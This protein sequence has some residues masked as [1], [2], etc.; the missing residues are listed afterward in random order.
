MTLVTSVAYKTLTF[1]EIVF[2]QKN[3]GN[4]SLSQQCITIG[5]PNTEMRLVKSEKSTLCFMIFETAKVSQTH[6]V[7]SSLESSVTDVR[8]GIVKCRMLTGT[9][10]LQTNKQKFSRSTVSATCTWGRGHYSCAIRVPS[11]ACTEETVL[12]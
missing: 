1:L 8:K 4:Y 3:N 2:Q 6:I 12:S 10:L 11:F 5:L 7:W 9:Y